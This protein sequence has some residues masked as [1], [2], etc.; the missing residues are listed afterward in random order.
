VSEVELRYL[1]AS[2]EVLLHGPLPLDDYD[3][4]RVEQL[5]LSLRYA[6]DACAAPEQI[7]DGAL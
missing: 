5:H 7:E 1:K 4:A 3:R 6:L 2:A